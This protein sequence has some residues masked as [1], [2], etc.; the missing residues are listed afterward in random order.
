M[1][2]APPPVG[3]I[4][5]NKVHCMR[6]NYGRGVQLSVVFLT[7]VVML[8]LMMVHH[9][10]WCIGCHL[11]LQLMH[12]SLHHPQLRLQLIPNYCSTTE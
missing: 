10:L 3:L 8:L 11:L 5:S 2:N 12:V 7:V 6:H 9:G 1:E 4:Y